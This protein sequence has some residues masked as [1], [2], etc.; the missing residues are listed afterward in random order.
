MGPIP[1]PEI[2][3]GYEK[4]LPGGADRILAMAATQQKH[5]HGMESKVLDSH[6]ARSQQGLWCGL[7]VAIGGLS[8]FRLEYLSVW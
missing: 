4:A 2:L 7:V 1:P 3:A 5:R 8:V 6:I